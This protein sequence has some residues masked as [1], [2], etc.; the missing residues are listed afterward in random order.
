MNKIQFTLHATH[1]GAGMMYVHILCT[2]F[3]KS[4]IIDTG[5]HVFSDE[6]DATLGLVV[7]NPNA[8][9]LIC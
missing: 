7:N 4:L 1:N 3:G 6:W 5:V 8:K 9:K 2:Q